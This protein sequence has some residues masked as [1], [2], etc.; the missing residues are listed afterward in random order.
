[1]NRC[2]T[3]TVEPTMLRHDYDFIIV[4]GGTSGS[5]LANRL[6]ENKNWNVLL[7]EAGRPES[8]ANFVPLL[9]GFLVKS[10]Y[11]WSYVSEKTPGSCL[12]RC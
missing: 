6:S 4:G 10:S 11:D 9:A 3:L 1:M 7:L 12:C 8:G 5:V 2:I